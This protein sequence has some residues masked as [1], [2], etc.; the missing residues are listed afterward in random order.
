MISL[1]KNLV[2]NPDGC[3]QQEI[4]PIL[5]VIVSC[6]GNKVKVDKCLTSVISVLRLVTRHIPVP[7]N[8]LGRIINKHLRPTLQHGV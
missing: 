5:H 4:G 7:F 2:Q 1:R 6:N 8:D 3:G